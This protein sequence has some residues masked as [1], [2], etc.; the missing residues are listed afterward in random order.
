MYRGNW[1]VVYYKDGKTYRKSMGTD[2]VEVAA[3]FRD[4]FHKRM[5]KQGAEYVGSVGRKKLDFDPETDQYIYSMHRVIVNG[6][7]V[8]SSKDIDK[9]REI[10]DT[11]LATIKE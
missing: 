5:L 7:T 2:D 4:I 8:G 10:R 1:N 3:F 9:A 6:V 11:Y